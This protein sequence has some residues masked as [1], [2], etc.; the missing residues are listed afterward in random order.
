MCQRWEMGMTNDNAPQ[1][2]GQPDDDVPMISSVET[3]VIVSARGAYLAGNLKALIARMDETQQ[4]QFHRAIVEQAIWNV[5]RVLLPENDTQRRAMQELRLWLTIGD[6]SHIDIA[7]LILGHNADG[8]FLHSAAQSA[9]ESARCHTL[10]VA[11]NRAQ[12]TARHAADEEIQRAGEPHDGLHRRAGWSARRWQI[13]AAWAILINQEMPALAD[14]V[15]NNLQGIY[16]SG[17]LPGL[18]ENMGIEQQRHFMQVM[19]AQTLEFARQA[20]PAPDRDQG[21]HDCLDAARQCFENPN[22]DTI[23]A[24][25]AAHEQYEFRVMGT[26]NT[27][28][29]EAALHSAIF[30]GQV[31]MSGDPHE[32]AEMSY[33]GITKAAKSIRDKGY[34]WIFSHN[35]HW[36]QIEAAWAILHDEPIPPLETP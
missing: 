26:P 16:R 12:D 20:L 2:G 30:A 18:I 1:I 14:F 34:E 7:A 22:S 11:S 9:I 5:E 33:R 36:W 29:G 3:R 32:I 27:R 28:V 24:F 10:P 15:E 8:G 35:I 25:Q 17:N 19:I 21:E 23:A 6:H 13:E 31:A 4:A